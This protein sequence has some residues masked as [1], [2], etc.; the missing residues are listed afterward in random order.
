VS[1]SADATKSL[2]LDGT[3]TL[4]AITISTGTVTAQ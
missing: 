1:L 4:T 2:V 3:G